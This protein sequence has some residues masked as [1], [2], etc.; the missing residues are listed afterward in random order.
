MREAEIDITVIP[1][2]V[3]PTPFNSI[4]PSRV[5]SIARELPM[6]PTRVSGGSFGFDAVAVAS[7]EAGSPVRFRRKGLSKIAC[8]FASD[9]R[10]DAAVGLVAGRVAVLDRLT[11][12]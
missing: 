1:A 6:V 2:T 8:I 12:L 11:G 9:G 5:R 4:F 3:S 7:A 10:A